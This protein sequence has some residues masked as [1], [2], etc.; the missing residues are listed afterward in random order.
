MLYHTC[1]HLEIRNQHNFTI[2]L[3]HPPPPLS[4]C[5]PKPLSNTVGSSDAENLTKQLD[6]ALYSAQKSMSYSYDK[7]FVE[8]DLEKYQFKTGVIILENQ[9]YPEKIETVGNFAVLVKGYGAILLHL[10]LT[11]PC[12]T[13]KSPNMNDS[14]DK[15]TPTAALE[16]K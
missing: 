5:R 1:Q 9:D 14:S 3:I 15:V 11:N 16:Q 2:A 4:H 13:S 6:C 7:G 10:A 8:K 12:T